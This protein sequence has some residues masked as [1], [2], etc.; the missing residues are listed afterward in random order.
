MMQPV[1]ALRR[2]AVW[3]L[4]QR[5]DL[6]VQRIQYQEPSL[7]IEGYGRVRSGHSPVLA[8]PHTAQRACI[9]APRERQ[10]TKKP[11]RLGHRIRRLAP[12]ERP[13]DY[14]AQGAHHWTVD[15]LDVISRIAQTV[16]R[17]V[18][19]RIRFES[20]PSRAVLFHFHQER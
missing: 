7:A 11:T 15:Q 13:S 2:G 10:K 16:K 5:L 6:L 8:L 18:T 14:P 9:A 19:G 4:S 12:L 1:L 20:P 17:G 3:Q